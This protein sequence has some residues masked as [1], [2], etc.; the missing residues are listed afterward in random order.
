MRPG[1][2]SRPVA[3]DLVQYCRGSCAGVDD[4]A[5][6]RQGE[7]RTRGCG[8]VP[9]R[10]ALVLRRRDDEDGIRAE[11]AQRVLDRP[12]RILVAKLAPGVD[13]GVAQPGQALVEVT[14]RLRA[15]A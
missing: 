6:D 8:D 12:Q 15:C 9:Y 3:A 10:S 7:A 11:G 2:S 14:L 13:P 1:T 5:R 4:D